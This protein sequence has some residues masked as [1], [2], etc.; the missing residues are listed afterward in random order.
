MVDIAFN[1]LNQYQRY[2]WIL[3]VVASVVVIIEVSIV[4][5]VGALVVVGNQ[6]ATG[7]VNVVIGD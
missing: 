1:N 4:V 3:P 2:T 6:P 5:V 7:T